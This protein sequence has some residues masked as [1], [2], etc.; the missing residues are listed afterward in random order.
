MKQGFFWIGAPLPYPVRSPTNPTASPREDWDAIL[1]GLRDARPD[2]AHH[3]LPSVFGKEAGCE[4]SEHTLR[5]FEQIVH[6]ADALAIERCIQILTNTDLTEQ[7]RKLGDET[8]LPITCAHGDS[9][10]GCTLSSS[11]DIIQR[12][13]PRTV[14]K[15]YKDGAHGEEY[16]LFTP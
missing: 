11:V 2:F 10:L 9:D 7:L 5:R 6:S 3:S 8:N 15:L 1:H 16:T 13:I 14:L 12:I 4:L